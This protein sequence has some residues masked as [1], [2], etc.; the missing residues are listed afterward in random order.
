MEKADIFFMNKALKQAEKAFK[1]EEVPGGAVVVQSGKIIG[2]GFNKKESKHCSVYHAE[3]VAL[4]SACKKVGDWRL[5]DATLYVT[6]EPCVMCAGAIV[7]HRIKRVVIGVK[8]AN[9]GA[10]GSGIDI[11]NNSNL[12]TKTEVEFGVLEEECKD[13]LQKFFKER[14]AKGNKN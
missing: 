11:L 4:K 1:L 10:C 2:R 6:M 5:N 14:R 3:I 9:F 13:I 12:N 8:E 7:N